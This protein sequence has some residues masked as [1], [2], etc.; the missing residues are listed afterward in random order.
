MSR[1]PYFRWYPADAVGDEKYAAMNDAELGFYH[2][3]LDSAWLNTGLPADLD[4]LAV[5]F[6]ITRTQLQKVWPRVSKCWYE[7]NGRLFNHRQEAERSHV[8][9]KAEANRR[10]GNANAKK[11]NANANSVKRERVPEKR[12]E[13]ANG[14]QRAYDSDSVS[15]SV[16]ETT[17][18]EVKHLLPS[19]G[20]VPVNGN[21]Q[22]SM[23]QQNAWEWFCGVFPGELNPDYDAGIFVSVIRTFED[24]A[25][26]RKNLPG[27]LATKKW[28]DGFCPTAENYIRKRQF[29]TRPK[30]NAGSHEISYTLL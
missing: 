3:C 13:N 16:L 17:N 24:I 28:Q 7:E 8:I 15:G 26:L 27:W 9:A 29:K 2:R 4:E 6:G 10:P 14:P 20:S 23:D 12:V 30:E 11:E 19:D 22:F 18:Q 1:L 25:L 5:L 21:G